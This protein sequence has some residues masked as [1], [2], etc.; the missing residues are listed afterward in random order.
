[1]DQSDI[2]PSGELLVGLILLLTVEP[3]DLAVDKPVALYF[4]LLT[5]ADS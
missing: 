5:S 1:M 2:H 3:L 4:V